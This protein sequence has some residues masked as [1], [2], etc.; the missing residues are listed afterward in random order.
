M[1]LTASSG[2]AEEVKTIDLDTKQ[3]CAVLAGESALLGQ[4]KMQTEA[5]VKEVT[6]RMEDIRG[7][8]GPRG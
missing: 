8:R 1:A 3:K 6:A 2:Y 5:F 4:T 7:G